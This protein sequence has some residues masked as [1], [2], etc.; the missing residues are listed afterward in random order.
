MTNLSIEL[1]R[2]EKEFVKFVTPLKILPGAAQIAAAAD[3]RSCSPLPPYTMQFQH[4]QCKRKLRPDLP[5]WCLVERTLAAGRGQNSRER[6]ESFSFVL[7]K[8]SL[9]FHKHVR[10][11][12][13]QRLRAVQVPFLRGSRF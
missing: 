9:G 4:H 2:D 13:S 3:L 8:S 1:C 10:A 7:S 11:Y 5:Q 12:P 6:S